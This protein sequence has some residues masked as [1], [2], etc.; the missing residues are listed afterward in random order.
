MKNG[1]L[2][3]G[4]NVVDLYLDRGVFFPGGNALNVAVLARRFGLSDVA[5]MGIVGND[6]EGD[7][8]RACMAA[9]GLSTAHLRR[10]EGAN[11]KA[12]VTHDAQGDRVFVASNRGGI[13]RKLMLRMD[14]DDL[15][16]IADMGHVHS[17]CFS[18]LE[19][20][21]PRIRAA[22]RGVSFDFSTLHDPAY[23]AQVCPYVT[24]AFLSGQGLDDAAVSD[25][26]ARVLDLGPD[27]V[28]VTRGEMGAVWATG[29]SRIVQPVVPATVVDTMGAGDAFI[30]GYLVG[31]LG[32][33]APEQGLPFAASCAAKA[34]GWKGAWGYPLAAKQ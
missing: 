11:G 25:L 20:E 24:T 4:D 13:R 12:Q 27:S 34:C 15:A 32:G 16:L 17:S 33:Q 21:L 7:H 14:E 3:I 10:V 19:P 23:L 30:A 31:T 28:C 9:E 8:V 18:Y 22:A 29:K 6:R 2:C 26:I 1:L 5:Y